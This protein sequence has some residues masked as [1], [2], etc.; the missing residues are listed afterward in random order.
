M[1]LTTITALASIVAAIAIG[2]EAIAQPYSQNSTETRETVNFRDHNSLPNRLSEKQELRDSMI[3]QKE[4]GALSSQT[5]DQRKLFSEP[6]YPSAAQ[7][8]YEEKSFSLGER[9]SHIWILQRRLL[10]QGFEPGP[11]DSVF[12]S[13]T[14]EAV[15]AFQTSRG[16]TATG[17]VNETTWKALTKNQRQVSPPR[18]LS[19]KPMASQQLRVSQEQSVSQE[20]ILDQGN[21]G[22]KVRT[23]QLR[24]D[25]KGYDPG[26]IDGVF[27]AKTAAAVKQFQEAQGLSTSGVVDEATWEALGRN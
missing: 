4:S 19:E 24:L 18:Q 10:A 11:V 15:K 25:I 1:R 27:G 3:V 26:P 2:P 16:L 5:S 21:K 12:G 13:K 6:F 17:V 20:T 8:R 22:S 7:R 9:G 14:Q 23:L